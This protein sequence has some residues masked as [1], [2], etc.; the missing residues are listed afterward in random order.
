MV[1]LTTLGSGP[2][3]LATAADPSAAGYRMPIF[4]EGDRVVVFYR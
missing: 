4:G 2:I 1:L 3:T